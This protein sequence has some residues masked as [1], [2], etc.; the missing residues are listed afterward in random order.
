MAGA[1]HA[2]P[3]MTRVA[4]MGIVRKQWPRILAILASGH[5]DLLETGDAPHT[6]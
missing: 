1:D 3:T 4:S 2:M 5:A 6:G